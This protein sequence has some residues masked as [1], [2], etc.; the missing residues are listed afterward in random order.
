MKL[1]VFTDDGYQTPVKSPVC[2]AFWLSLVSEKY[3][4]AISERSIAAQK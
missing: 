3:L 4:R 2:A 1:K